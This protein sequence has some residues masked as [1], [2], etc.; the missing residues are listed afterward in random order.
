MTGNPVKIG[1]GCAT[2]TD[3]EFPN[4]TVG[5]RGGSGGKAGT[6]LEVRSQDTGLAALV[7]PE[8][9]GALLR[10]EKDE[11]SRRERFSRGFV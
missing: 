11:A 3:Y 6:R 5:P 9:F 2:V 8:R 7:S 4:A 10:K 1:D